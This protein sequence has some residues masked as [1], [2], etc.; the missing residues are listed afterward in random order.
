MNELYS[1]QDLLG[2]SAQLNRRKIV[3][4]AVSAVLLG[5]LVW[6]IVARIEALSIALLILLGVVLIFS[7]EMFVRPLYAYRRLILT[8][9]H[10]RSHEA[11]L[12]YDHREEDLSTVDG[13]CCHS[14]IFLGD[15]DKHGTREQLY[16]WDR[17]KE[18]PPFEPGQDV[19]I[20]Y[21]GKMILGWA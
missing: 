12:T 19:R 1:Q 3:I 7:L 13:V 6:S 15:P 14:L 17:E 16:Y 4:L 9:L 21:S 8:A 20:R 11:Q 2:I 10:G 18:L 5:A